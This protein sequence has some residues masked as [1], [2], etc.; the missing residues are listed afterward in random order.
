MRS[1]PSAYSGPFIADME[2]MSK[3]MAVWAADYIEEVLETLMP[4][5]RGWK[6]VLPT[7]NERLID[8]LD[9]RGNP[10][11]WRKWIEMKVME[12]RQMLADSGLTEDIIVDLG[13]DDIVQPMA[14]AYSN[15]YEAMLSRTS[16]RQDPSPEEDESDV[17]VLPDDS[18]VS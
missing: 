9:I 7:P 13:V 4:D 3:D 2:A 8:Y 5:R 16:E 1:S 12:V 17:G 15:A 11:A 6:E 14:I 18:T 10:D